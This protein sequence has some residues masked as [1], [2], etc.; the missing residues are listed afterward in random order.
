MSVRIR[1]LHLLALL[2]FFVSTPSVF[3]QDARQDPVYL[4]GK[5]IFDAQCASCHAVHKQVVGPALAGIQTRRDAAWLNAWIKNSQAVVKS[6]DAYAVEIFNK[7]NKS[8]MPAFNLSDADIANILTYVQVETDLPPVAGTGKGEENQATSPGSS[9]NLTIF[10]AI[11]LL[12]LALIVFILSRLTGTLN[13]MNKEK[14]GQLVPEPMELARM[15]FSKKMAAFAILAFLIFLGYSTVEN[16]QILGRQK[17]YQPAQP[18]KFSHKLHA[19]INKIECQYCHWGAAKGKAAVIPSPNLC[20][21]CHKAIKEGPEYGTTEIGKI[22]AAV[23][24]NPDSMRYE[25]NFT[26]RAIEWVRIHNLPDHVYF[27]HSQHVT[28]GGVKCQTCHGE[29]QEMEV[30]SQ[31]QTLGMG[32]CVNCHRETDVNFKGN[33][34]YKDY[35]L[36]HQQLKDGRIQRVTVEDIGGTECQ[37]CH[38]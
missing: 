38:Y 24:W 17:N 4:S 14:M 33:N 29:I 37:K 2:T 26:P 18:I 6:G 7:Y 16:A 34:F 35:E 32:W 8:V 9:T 13:R 5:T 20:M 28:A 31:Y 11:I 21:N 19:G 3:A 30:A 15:V 25:P 1:F 12:I 10:L 22:Y 27:N 23:G 36:L